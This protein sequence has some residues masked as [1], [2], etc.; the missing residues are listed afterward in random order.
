MRIS[1]SAI[2]TF[3]TCPLKYKYQ[4][5][6]RIKVPKTKEAV[7]GS[8]IHDALKFLHSAGPLFPTLEQFL[9]NFTKKWDFS[10][11]LVP[12]DIQ[13]EKAYF[14]QGRKILENYYKTNSPFQFNIVDLESFF[15]VPLMGEKDEPHLLT[16]KIDRI[17]KTENDSLEVI[18][19]KTARRMPPQK[20][21][22][23]DLQLSLYH[24][25]VSHRWP[26]MK[27]PVK[28]TLYFLKHGEKL[29]T[30]R[31][32]KDLKETRERLLDLIKQVQESD[33]QPKPGPLCDWCG[34]RKMCPMWKHLYQKAEVRS[35]KS[36]EIKKLIDEYFELQ[37]GNKKNDMRLAEIKGLINEYLDKEN[38]ERVFGEEGY[39]MRTLQKRYGYDAQKIKEILTPF[40]KWEDILTI[41]SKKLEKIL[42]SLPNEIREQIK[43]TRRVEKEFKALISTKNL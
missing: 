14:N 1:Y 31:S 36:E 19:Y 3:Q 12:W 24:L 20:R 21:V 33:F 32:P 28:L 7:F 25:G 16:G 35:M 42:K 37:K 39:I 29:S 41:D 22:D 4:E 27:K 9:E 23:Q 26:E 18:D 6:D 8:I 30:T 11:E 34:Y 17:D 15:E 43:K 40:G 13:E 10:R 38:L 5:I 2:D